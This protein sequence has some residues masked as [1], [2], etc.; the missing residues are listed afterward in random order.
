MIIECVN[1][2]KKFEVD[3]TLIPQS[4]RTVQ[5]GF[6]NHKWF[7]NNDEESKVNKIEI[8]ENLSKNNI[9]SKHKSK[10]PEKKEPEK[11]SKV[12]NSFKISKFL[13]YILVF[14][15]SIIALIIILD[16]FKSSLGNSF[17][18]LDLVLFNLFE[19]LKDISLFIKDVFN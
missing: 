3:S 14:I 17:P 18:N 2:N 4:G 16:T 15:I 7:F 9:K 13:S 1:C 12:V 11:H 6:C 8:V 10:F 5:C 19:S